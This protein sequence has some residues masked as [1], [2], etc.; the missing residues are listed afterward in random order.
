MAP[1]WAHL[2]HRRKEAILSSV[3]VVILGLE[4]LCRNATL[5]KITTVA[6]NRD[7]VA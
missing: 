3:I 7:S 1:T 2:Q 6:A 5:P 4:L